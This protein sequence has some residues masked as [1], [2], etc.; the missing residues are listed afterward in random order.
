[1]CEAISGEEKRFRGR[2]EAI[3]E[4]QKSDQNTAL[5][6]DSKSPFQFRVHSRFC[7]LTCA[8]N[9]PDILISNID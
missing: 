1:M 6:E 7:L 3:R 2:A 4:A 8:D 9:S 5:E